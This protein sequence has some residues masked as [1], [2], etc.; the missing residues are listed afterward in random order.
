MQNTIQFYTSPAYPQSLPCYFQAPT[1]A[2]P[3]RLETPFVNHSFSQSQ[4]MF[5][6]QQLP[7]QV[8]ATPSVPME[9]EDPFENDAVF[10]LDEDLE[11]DYDDT[12]SY[13]E[14]ERLADQLLQTVDNIRQQK[15]Q[16]NQMLRQIVQ[17]NSTH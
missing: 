6:E 9:E 15:D 5:A 7:Q 1:L 10:D 13:D 4:F 8:V 12:N 14:S 2:M 11:E 3:N 17:M 16:T